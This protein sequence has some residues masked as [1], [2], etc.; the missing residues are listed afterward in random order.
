MLM[1]VLPPMPPLLALLLL[2]VQ[3]AMIPPRRLLV[4]GFLWPMIRRG[5]KF[6]QS[7]C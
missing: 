1:A 3:L 2:G 4:C 5:G 7:A 6:L